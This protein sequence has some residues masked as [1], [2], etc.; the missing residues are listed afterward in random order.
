MNE[1]TTEQPIAPLESWLRL[2]RIPNLLTVPGDPIAGYLL[3]LI[4]S[5]AEF[6]LPAL[7]ATVMASLC[8]YCFGLILN[9]LVDLKVDLRERPE[10]PLPSG[11]ITVNAA[12]G[13]AV[14]L[15][16]TGLN[17]ALFAGVPVLCAAAVLALLIMLYNA[18]AKRLPVVGA[19]AMGLCRGGSFLLGALAALGAPV[20]LF[21]TDLIPLLFGFAAVTL[22]LFGVSVVARGEMEQ[23]KSFGPQRW[24]P[25]IALLLTLPGV[26]VALSWLELFGQIAAVAYVFLMVMTLMRAWL[27]GGLMYRAQS[28]PLTVGGHIRNHLMTQAAL[29]A[30]S[31]GIGLAVAGA[32]VLAS[33]LFGTLS[34]RFYSS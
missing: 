21:S 13:V 7:T 1:L 10:R 2:L 9:D 15:A 6:S 8:L 16:F 4:C 22:S 31:G 14:A 24:L 12:R 28:V 20:D 33:Q 27:L 29:C 3:A 25:F 5:T 19:A 34:R 18:G 17:L 30:A 26:V 32:L 11:Q 23:E